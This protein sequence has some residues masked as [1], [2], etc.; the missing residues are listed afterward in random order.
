[1]GKLL[2][3]VLLALM[4]GGCHTALTG[5]ARIV[6]DPAL[7]YSIQIA[8]LVMARSEDHFLIVQANI[9]NTRKDNIPVEYSVQFLDQNGL[10]IKS[11]LDG[12]TTVLLAPKET[13]SVSVVA[14]TTAAT[15]CRF[16]VR[17]S[18]W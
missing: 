11:V 17:K 16:L 15:D 3:C 4:L 2:F 9:A 8:P 1:M 12:W 18:A 10:V 7:N 5:D 14:P 6:V 13:R